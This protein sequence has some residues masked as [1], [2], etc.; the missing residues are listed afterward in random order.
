MN[1]SHLRSLVAI[2]DSGSFTAA[3]EAMGI[4]QSGVSQ[5]VA[6]LEETLGVALVVRHRRG[7][8][9]TAAGE[10][11]AAYAREALGALDRIRSEADTTRGIA[12]GK[13]RLASYPSVFLTLL[14]ALLRRFRTRYPDIQVTALEADD[15]EVE[16]WLAAGIVDLGVVLNPA[17]GRAAAMLGRD[18]WVPVLPRAHRLAQH[19]AIKLGTLA[20]E[21]FVLATGGCE[22]NART[23]AQ[24]AGTPL[25]DIQV[26]VRDWSSAFALVRE[27]TGISLVPESTLPEIRRGLW[28]G[29]LAEPLYRTFGLVTS[30]A[31]TPSR[32]VQ[33][34]V[35]AMRSEPTHDT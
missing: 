15:K 12:E 26:E 22:A 8:D 33:T 25:T 21:P 30:P 19:T 13:V 14:P 32:A 2:A 20:T 24:A 6:A 10:R 28:I 1:L 35:E 31:K 23:L 17:P 16:D 7:A 18:A 27:G 11:I 34:F 4:T 5:A 29:T 3:A 9:L